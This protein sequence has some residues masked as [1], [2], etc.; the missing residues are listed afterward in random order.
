MERPAGRT[1]GPMGVALAAVIGWLLIVSPAVAAADPQTLAG[2]DLE[3][4]AVTNFV[5][6]C[7]ATPA[8][9]GFDLSG[10]ATGPYPGTFAAHV[11]V[12]LDPTAD[13]HHVATSITIDSAAG[14]VDLQASH[15]GSPAAVASCDDSGGTVGSV[16]A[17]FSAPYNARLALPTPAVDRG[18]ATISWDVSE[19]SGGDP[20][21]AGGAGANSF[22][23]AS[24]LTAPLTDGDGDGVP[25]AE[26]NCPS[27]PNADQI[28]HDHDGSGDVCDP[29]DDN[30]GVPDASDNC[31]FNGNPDQVDTD[32]DGIGTACDPDAYNRIAGVVTPLTGKSDV[33]GATDGGLDDATFWDIRSIAAS[34]DSLYLAVSHDRGNVSADTVNETW[35][36]R[37]DLQTGQVETLLSPEKLDAITAGWSDTRRVLFQSIVYEDGA[38]YAAGFQCGVDPPGGF[39]CASRLFRYDVATDTLERLPTGVAADDM[40]E[41]VATDGTS[42]YVT[43]DTCTP[44]RPARILRIPFDG[45]ATDTVTTLPPAESG[46]SA[47]YTLDYFD[48]DLYTTDRD[49]LY[50]IDAATGA[51]D[52]LVGPQVVTDDPAGVSLN[53]PQGLVVTAGVIYLTPDQLSNCR[54]LAIDRVTGHAASLAGP[55]DQ[56]NANCTANPSDPNVLGTGLGVR[57]HP[58]RMIAYRGKL[59]VTDRQ[60]CLSPCEQPNWNNSVLRQVEILPDAVAP[61]GSA[62]VPQGI[63]APRAARRSGF[64][65]T[66]AATDSGEGRVPSGVA[67]FQVRCASQC[68]PGSST[69]GW[70]DYQAGR[71]T[72]PV[73]SAPTQVRFRDGAKNISGWKPVT[74]TKA[75]RDGDGVADSVDN[76]PSVANPSQANAD[77]DAQ[78]DAC[79]PDDDNDGRPDVSDKCPTKAGPGRPSGC[80][81]VARKLSASFK[82]SK[83]RFQGVLGAGSVAACASRQ[84][85]TLLRRRRGQDPTIAQT[86]TAGDGSWSVKVAKPRHGSYY[87]AVGAITAAGVA[88]CGAVSSKAVKVG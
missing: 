25:D 72:L 31:P 49:H 81:L 13:E 9:V 21:L 1:G 73:A 22:S 27:Q 19:P 68:E 83:K 78:G 86:Q 40:L 79:D 30:D 28:D 14:D 3:A 88:D 35:L 50:V 11:D 67:S 77:G 60:L 8:H 54:V 62:V 39:A 7:D 64:P 43:Q 85:V 37:V 47:H 51:Q 59:Y 10:A 52:V 58:G 48:G 61:Q 24:S 36:R 66:L 23:L 84:K 87:A 56:S 76:C 57:W 16:A 32:H 70:L 15:S 53:Y 12:D 33:F 82:A 4:S 46:C 34:G 20:V 6:H 42:L 5:A 69:T 17:G 75:D 65:L 71:V 80:P 29:D 45:G 18:D 26:D 55:I 44:D 63:S 41:A 74:A 2:E 38:I